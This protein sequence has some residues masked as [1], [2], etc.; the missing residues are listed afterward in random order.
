MHH[1]RVY[2]LVVTSILL[3]SPTF[4]ADHV[5]SK[6]EI[7]VAS[8]VKVVKE[9]HSNFEAHVDS[10]NRVTMLGSQEERSEFEKCMRKRK[11]FLN[12]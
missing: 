3:S 1:V 7:V 9:E 8:C 10:D 4:A 5:P 2:I 11:F 12:W 6:I